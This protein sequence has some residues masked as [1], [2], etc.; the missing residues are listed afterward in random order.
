M[1]LGSDI[2]VPGAAMIVMAIEAMSQRTEALHLVEGKLPPRAPCYRVRN[3]TF[4]RAL[5]LEEGKKQTIQI[6]LS[7]RAGSRDSWQEFKIT[8]LVN[9]SWFEHSRGLVRVEEDRHE[10]TS[11]E[12]SLKSMVFHL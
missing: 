11:R 7:A 9:G 1:Q 4:T 8:S 6:G 2:V 5:V 3:A 10:G 12:W